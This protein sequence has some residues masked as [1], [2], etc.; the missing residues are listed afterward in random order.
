[1]VGCSIVLLL[2]YRKNGK[3]FD[4][5]IPKNGINLMSMQSWQTGSMFLWSCFFLSMRSWTFFSY[6]TEHLFSRVFIP[7]ECLNL[8]TLDY[9]SSKW[10]FAELFPI[11][12]FYLQVDSKLLKHN[13]GL[14][15]CTYNRL[16]YNSLSLFFL[17]I[18]TRFI[19]RDSRILL[20]FAV[21]IQIWLL[22]YNFL[23]RVTTRYFALSSRFNLFPWII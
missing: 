15:F 23:V 7:T 22:N 16:V 6:A 17:S 21:V 4:L 3:V 13:P 8:V 5:M 10:I 11:F 2:A 18:F 14:G 12:I 19:S 20:A 9:F 1:M